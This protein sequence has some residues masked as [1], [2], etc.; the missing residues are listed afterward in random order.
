MM[1]SIALP[2]GIDQASGQAPRR[3]LAARSA[4]RWERSLG[5]REVFTLETS[6]R[7]N[8]MCLDGMLWITLER[9]SFDY[10]LAPGQALRVPSGNLA[11]IQALTESRF[12]VTRG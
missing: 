6:E 7:V 2:A 12:G 1:T 8:L 10:V 3:G 11:A 9:D 4:P 5:R